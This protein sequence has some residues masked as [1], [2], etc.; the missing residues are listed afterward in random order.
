MPRGRRGTAR[1]RRLVRADRG[2]A[3]RRDAAPG[4]PAAP[5]ASRGSRSRRA[6]RRAPRGSAC[7]SPS[8]RGSS[9]LA[10]PELVRLPAHR[11]RRGGRRPSPGAGRRTCT[12]ASRRCRRPSAR[13]SISAVL[14][15]VH[16]VDAP[17]TPRRA[18]AR[19][20]DLA[21]RRDRAHGVRGERARDE[22]GPRRRARVE[23]VEVERDVLR[24]DVHPPHGR[25]CVARREHPRTDV[26]VVV[27]PRDDDLV[28][29]PR[30]SGRTTAT[31][32]A[33][34]TSRSVRR[35][36]RS[37]SAPRRSAPARRA[38]RRSASSISR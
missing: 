35:P 20:D 23:G 30:A 34:A 25:A 18:F 21:D 6:C 15:E 17:R 3:R 7:P 13:R 12:G 10:A 38:S 36:P 9:S 33:A 24:S 26:R 2:V 19:A 27:Q 8:G 31:G 28:A 14:R 5:S 32:A 22:P 11:A 4:V 29:G 1:Q 16:A 37:G